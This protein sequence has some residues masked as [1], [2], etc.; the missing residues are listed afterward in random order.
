M[1]EKPPNPHSIAI[2]ASFF[3]TLPLSSSFSAQK[4]LKQPPP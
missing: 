4:P 3:E 1:V 2:R